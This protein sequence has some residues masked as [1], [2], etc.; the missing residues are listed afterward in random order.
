[1]RS[2]YLISAGAVLTAQF[3]YVVYLGQ[4]V[5]D[6]SDVV[7]DLQEKSSLHGPVIGQPRSNAPLL[8]LNGLGEGDYGGEGIYLDPPKSVIADLAG[9]KD[10]LSS[11]RNIGELLAPPGTLNAGAIQSEGVV[12]DIG[13]FLPVGAD[14][15]LGADLGGSAEERNIGEDRPLP[16]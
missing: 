11:D 16:N 1:M 15:V 4:S 7:R 3:A 10:E 8:D 12:V 2:V 5:G 9:S 13:P 14:Q 6:L